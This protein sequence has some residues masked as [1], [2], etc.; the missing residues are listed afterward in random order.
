VYFLREFTLSDDWGTRREPGGRFRLKGKPLK[1]LGSWSWQTSPLVGTRPYQGLLVILMLFNSSDLKNDNNTVYEYRVAD[2]VESWYVVRD[3][4]TALGSTGRFAPRRG[5]A[6]A[7][8]RHPF[9]T[10]VRGGVV[11]FGYGGWHQELVRQRIAVGDV[12]WAATLMSRLT[13]RQWDEAFRAGGYSAIEAAPFLDAIRGRIEQAM[14]VGE[15]SGVMS[16]EER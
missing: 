12:K 8:R 4:G 16:R 14:R 9:I 15:P 13:E 6:E 7:F 11:E 10:G 2:R 3:L 1:D 5:D